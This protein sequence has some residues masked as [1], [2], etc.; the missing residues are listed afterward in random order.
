MLHQVDECGD[1]GAQQFDTRVTV[2]G[3]GGH[4]PRTVEHQS[5]GRRLAG[6]GVRRQLTTQ[7][8]KTAP[9]LTSVA[10]TVTDPVIDD[11]AVVE[12]YET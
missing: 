9:V 7:G 12:V 3:I 8:P 1:R 10:W 6:H 2:A 5:D 4:A 11:P